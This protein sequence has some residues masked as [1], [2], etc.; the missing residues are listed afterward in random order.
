MNR[1]SKLASAIKFGLIAS[2]STSAITVTTAAYAEDEAQVERIQV[3]GSRIQRQDME[4]ASPVTV[5]DASTIKASGA[6]TIDEVLQ[7][8]TSV[9][10]AQTNPGLNNG[11]QG[12]ATVNL[13]GLGA[14]RTLV[15]VNGR[16]MVNSGTGAAS[17]VDLNTIPVSMVKRV[18]VLKDGASAVYGSDAVAGVVNIIL[19]DDFQGFEANL[20]G[21]LSGHGDAA[22]T[23]MDITLGGDFDGGNAV[24]SVQ[25]TNRGSASQG[26]RDFSKCPIFEG[27][28]GFYCGGS[29]YTEGGHI[30]T[31]NSGDFQV[32]PDGSYKAY[33]SEK[34]A[35]NY[36]ADSY[37]YT[38]MQRLNMAASGN[39]ELTD[40]TTLF[41]EVMYSKRWS[42]QSMAPQ[43]I[44]TQ[45]AYKSSMDDGGLLAEGVAEGEVLSY[46]R[47]M[48]DIGNR[49]YK[50][51]VDT[52][53]VVT[54]LQGYLDNDMSWDVS[55]NY[56]R[57]DSID[58]VENYLNMGSLNDSI[59]NGSFNPLD[60][61]AWGSQL[62]PYTYTE[63]NTGG[64]EM[65][66]S[67][68]NLSGDIY[69]LPAGT[70]GFA[71]GIEYRTEKAWFTPDSLSSQGLANDPATESTSGEYSVKE[72]YLE[73]AIPLLADL[74]GVEN[75][76]MSAA[77]RGFDYSTFGSDSTWKLGL[78]WKVNDDLMLRGV[79]S[80]A[81]RAPSVDELYGGVSTSYD[82]VIDPV[83]GEQQQAQVSRGG[84]DMLTPEEA[85][86]Y[87][88]GFVYSPTYLDGFSVTADYYDIAITD[89]I[90]LVDSNYIVKQCMDS[91]GNPINNGSAL[92]QSADVQMDPISG[93]IS[94]NNQLQNIGAENTSGIDINAAYAFDA[95]GLDW[96]VGFDST[97]LL[98]YEN[99]IS[100]E[101]VDYKGMITSGVGSYAE[102]KNNL[103]LN[104]RGDD[105]STQYQ[106][107]YISSLDSYD[108]ATG[109]L[110]GCMA[111]ETGSIVYQ[112]VSASYYVTNSLTVSGGINNLFDVEPP[113][114]SGN[115]DANTDPY[116]YDTLGRYFYLQLSVKM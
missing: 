63:Q 51:V 17:T 45:F 110:T 81:F 55:V 90:A 35:Y 14:S 89:S 78:T 32:N 70:L 67:S 34:D 105:W 49:M 27:E 104:V 48:T 4:T 50:Q 52:A 18:E 97:I 41:S 80:T 83:T 66:I 23:A 64:S 75:L 15:L 54:G 101:V 61:N 68:A 58:Q 92:C 74:P 38:P 20:Q 100:G 98:S 76:D 94:F 73:L 36:A 25:Y 22:K 24:M 79:A 9:S 60:Q 96:K 37:L 113:Y 21:G 16:R 39:Y 42:E 84:N 91:S 46:R 43:P 115:N 31:E 33:D 72:A 93:Q 112:D 10:G 114:Y 6:V 8:M 109:G 56:G 19:K 28:N 26:D 59:E 71:T 111:P 2:I 102:Y 95:Y 82:Q 3:T 29:S 5:I 12:N 47:R 53:R 30:Y 77:I 85:K 99:E 65:L 88:A 11:S 86:T 103:T 69:E 87:T 1:P 40:D 44:S 106:A 57:N 116:T 107:R 7:K 62:D 108:C 13:R